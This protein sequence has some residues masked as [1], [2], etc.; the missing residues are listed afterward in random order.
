MSFKVH[1]RKD[2]LESE[3]REE[4]GRESLRARHC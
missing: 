1:M 3:D 4:C 2:N